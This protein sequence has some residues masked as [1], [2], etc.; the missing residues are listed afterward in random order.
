MKK[1]KS[2]KQLQ[3]E[4]KRIQ[5]RQEDLE[6]KIQGHWKELK[7]NLRPVNIV[8]ESLSKMMKSKTE[9]NL[10]GDGFMKNAFTYG[11]T[12]LAKKII[13]SAG[14]KLGKIFKKEPAKDN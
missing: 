8:K 11:V 5:Q 9:E 7:E 14:A 1:I 2:I 12:F 6:N 3:A 13:D 10:N 4:K